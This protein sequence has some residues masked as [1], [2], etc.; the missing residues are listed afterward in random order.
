M[1][2]A[3][4]QLFLLVIVFFG[5]LVLRAGER[6]LSAYSNNPRPATRTHPVL[7]AGFAL[8]TLG[9]LI[10]SE[11][12][13]F[14]SKPV[15]GDIELPGIART[16]AFLVVFAFDILG[17][18]FL[19]FITGG[20]KDSPFG[21]V[22]FT[23]PVL[24]IFLRESPG[25]FLGYTFAVAALFLLAQADTTRRVTDENPNLRTAFSFVTLGSLALTTMVGYATRPL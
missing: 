6:K 10:F 19:I 15:F 21:A 16:N 4:T 22:L 24:S 1:A 13:L 2:F 23:L 25:R 9:L 12:V 3:V 20:S 7:F 14:Y 11:D 17:A 8:F 5:I 18:A